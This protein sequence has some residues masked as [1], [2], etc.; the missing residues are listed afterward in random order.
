MSVAN[1]KAKMKIPT[2]QIVLQEFTESNLCLAARLLLH[3][4]QGHFRV[5]MDELDMDTAALYLRARG[6]QSGEDGSLA[7]YLSRVMPDNWDQ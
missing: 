5:C 6:A 7:V 4:A 3:I 1:W 2:Q